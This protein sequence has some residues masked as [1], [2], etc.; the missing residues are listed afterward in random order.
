MQVS[1]QADQQ[2]LCAVEWELRRK[3][4]DL[5]EVA[6]LLVLRK[7][8]GNLRQDRGPKIHAQIAVKPSCGS[9]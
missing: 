2:R 1:Q 4:K 5:A 7:N 6:A 9:R 3:E 8:R